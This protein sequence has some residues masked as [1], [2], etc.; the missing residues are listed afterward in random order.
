MAASAK[1]GPTTTS[2]WAFMLGLILVGIDESRTT[3]ITTISGRAERHVR[4]LPAKFNGRKIVFWSVYW[5]AN[6]WQQGNH[7]V[8]RTYAIRGTFNNKRHPNAAGSAP[9][10]KPVLPG[11]CS[12][13]PDLALIAALS[14]W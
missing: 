11:R 13:M 8:Y 14:S 6:S 7:T 5:G 3:S 9:E 2:R 1:P 10:H 12:F 4:T